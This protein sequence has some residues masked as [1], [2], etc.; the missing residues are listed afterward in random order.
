M[1]VRRTGHGSKGELVRVGQGRGTREEAQVGEYMCMDGCVRGAWLG[2][3][4]G[5][6]RRVMETNG[7]GGAAKRARGERVGGVEGKGK[8][9]DPNGKGDEG[10]RVGIGGGKSCKRL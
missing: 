1:T 9:R 8:S 7:A 6:V 4:V 5:K 3:E 10:E 2:I